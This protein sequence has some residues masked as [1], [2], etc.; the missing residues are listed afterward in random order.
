MKLQSPRRR[1]DI[2]S[3]RK[4]Y[5]SINAWWRACNYLSVGMIYLRDNPL[6]REPLTAEHVKLRLLGHWGASP[7][8]SFV[9]AHL[10]RHDRETRSGRDLRR[11]SGPRRAGGARA[12]LPRGHLLRGLSG[13]ERGRRGTAEVLQAVLFPR[14]DR[15]A[16][17]TGNARLDPRRRRARLQPLARLRDGARQPRSDRRLRR[18]RR[19]SGD[20][21]ARH[22]LALEQVHQPDPRRR[23]PADPQPE[24]LQ[25]R[26]PDDP[27]AHQPRGAG[28]AVCRLRLQAVLRRGQRSGRDAPDDGGDARKGDRRDSGAS[29]AGADDEHAVQT[30]LADD[31]AP[32]AEGL[33]RAEGD[34]RPQSRGL[35]AVAP[36][37]VLGRA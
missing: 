37:A 34:Q 1:Q 36:G 31:R 23:G 21:A 25:D 33:D 16:R 2:R 20:G 5:A 7:A 27:G 29:A 6:L 24:R 13:Q 3:A 26:Q 14:P 11:R 17:D 19:R 4:N 22:G 8:L 10:N 12:R 30:A 35:V 15:L 18:R 28:V 32:V 9:W